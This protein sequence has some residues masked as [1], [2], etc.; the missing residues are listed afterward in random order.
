M[1][2]MM[3][4]FMLSTKVALWDTMRHGLSGVPSHLE[5]DTSHTC[6]H[7]GN[8]ITDIIL[9]TLPPLSELLLGQRQWA[10]AAA[11]VT[12]VHLIWAAAIAAQWMSELDQ[13]T[14]TNR[15]S[16]CYCYIHHDRER[17]RVCNIVA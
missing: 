12:Y 1:T 17:E 9:E 11:V 13:W 5:D 14:G 8:R 7:C 4:V 2:H 15:Y 10:T 16:C 3:K 6:T